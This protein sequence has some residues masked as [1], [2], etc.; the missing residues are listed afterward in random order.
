MLTLCI[1]KYKQCESTHI[2]TLGAFS[3][4]TVHVSYISS[5]LDIYN[6]MGGEGQRTF[7]LSHKRRS[8]RISIHYLD[9]PFTC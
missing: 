8:A 7:Y 1:I 9:T 5:Y 4:M 6:A 2:E 3:H